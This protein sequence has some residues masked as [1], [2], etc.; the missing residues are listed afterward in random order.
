MNPPTLID[1]AK[2]AAD[3][4]G[5]L[6]AAPQPAPAAV[7]SEPAAPLTVTAEPMAAPPVDRFGHLFRPGFH[8][9]NVDGSPFR[10]KKGQ[11]MP[12]GGSRSPQAAAQP[13]ATAEPQPQPVPTAQPVQSAPVTPPITEPAAPAWTDAQRAAAAEPAAPAAGSPAAVAAATAQAE[14]IDSSDDAAEVIALAGFF[15]IGVIFGAPE[16]ATPPAGEQAHLIKINAALIRSTGWK[17]SAWWAAGLSW[18]AYLLRFLRKPVAAAQVQKWVA[19]IRAKSPAPDVFGAAVVT[20]I[21]NQPKPATAPAAP[22]A[23]PTFS[24]QFIERPAN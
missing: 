3:L 19:E 18:A 16:E 1:P 9:T 11:F 17:G 20:A 15:I 2:D 4:I 8:R 13:A 10:G 23:A 21:V 6:P 5:A 12:R 22:Q 24:G 7:P 14:I